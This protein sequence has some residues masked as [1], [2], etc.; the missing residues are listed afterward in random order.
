LPLFLHKRCNFLRLAY[1]TVLKRA[2]ERS[3][4]MK[5]KILFASVVLL[6]LAPM[7]AEAFPRFWPAVTFYY[8]PY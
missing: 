2:A 7:A 8:I 1:V 4:A 3:K 5:T 6:S